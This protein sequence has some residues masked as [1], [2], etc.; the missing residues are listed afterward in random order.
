LRGAALAASIRH[1]DDDTVSGYFHDRDRYGFVVTE[2]DDAVPD[3]DLADLEHVATL[4][5]AHAPRQRWLRVHSVEAPQIWHL[6]GR[7]PISRMNLS[8][9]L[10]S[11]R[12]MRSALRLSCLATTSGLGSRDVGLSMSV[13]VSLNV[14][15]GRT[16]ACGVR[17]GKRNRWGCADRPDL[18]SS[19]RRPGAVSRQGKAI[20]ASD[21]ASVIGAFVRASFQPKGGFNA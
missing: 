18:R 5:S 8:M 7:Q 6:S 3:H 20:S 1:L 13:I 14:A 9:R 16:V 10:R 15:Y 17:R 11:R 2:I 4:H 19:R 21:D 12:A